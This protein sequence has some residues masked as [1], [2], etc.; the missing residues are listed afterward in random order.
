M[1]KRQLPLFN[2][3]PT[4]VEDIGPQTP[5][6]ATLPFFRDYLASEGKSEHTLAAFMADLALLSD[7]GQEKT[8]IS[9]FTTRSLNDFLHWMEYERGVPC[10]RKTYA[11]RVTTLKVFFKWLHSLKALSD[12]PAKALIQR[13]GPAPLSDALSPSQVQDAIFAARQFKRD[14]VWDA[15]PLFLFQLLLQTGVKKGEA[16][17]L[18]LSDFDLSNSQQPVLIVRHKGAD[19]YK[20]RRIAFEPSL[21]SVLDSYRAQYQPQ[22]RVFTCTPRNLE[23]IL[24]DV[25]LSAGIPFKL[26]F[27]IMRWSCAVRDWRAGVEEEAIREKLGLSKISW[28]ETGD[29][30]RKLVAQQIE[31]EMAE[32]QDSCGSVDG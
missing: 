29:K 27:E 21:V 2:L 6:K 1:D 22:E 8:P 3:A 30:I 12:D 7:Y 24:T 11:R 15:R 28:Y 5:F 17:R 31:E 4:R 32:D 23:Y 20:E 13:S 19:V 9:Q 26:S 16:D 25:G 14:E 10:S 18:L